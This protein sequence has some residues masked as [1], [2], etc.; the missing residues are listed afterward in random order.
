MHD[1]SRNVIELINDKNETFKD[2]I[3]NISFD[4]NV[5]ENVVAVVKTENKTL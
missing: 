2:N 1:D 3:M 5:A 4:Y